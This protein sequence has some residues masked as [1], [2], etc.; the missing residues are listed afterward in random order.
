MNGKF[1][2]ILAGSALLVAATWVFAQGQ[3][4][5]AA[6][7]PDPRIDKIVDQNDQILKNQQEM[8]K[9]IADIKQD[10]LQLRRRSS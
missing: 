1:L 8:L 5:P 7:P 6:A 3:V 2:A 10:L 4:K 9:A